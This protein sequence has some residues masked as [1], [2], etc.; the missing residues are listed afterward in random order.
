MKV[1]KKIDLLKY[2]QAIDLSY[3]FYKDKYRK[4]IKIPY[5]TYLS[6]VSNLIIENNG[7]TDEI[8]AALFHDLFEF[9]NNNKRL[10][11]IKSKFGTKVLNIVKQC[12]SLDL[13][14]EKFIE[15]KKKFL[16]SMSK[17]SQSSLLVSLC[18]KLHS[19]NCIINDYN[20]IGKKLWRN[21]DLTSEETNWYYK[22]LCKNF[23]KFLKNHKSLKDKFQRNINELEFLIKK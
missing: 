18:D 9:K 6:S 22:I 7:S 10:N 19:I 17:M 11:Q 16:D 21:H 2:K 8:I 3:S 13:S 15:N 5:F 12:S 4:G 23:K 1:S 20:K 14:N